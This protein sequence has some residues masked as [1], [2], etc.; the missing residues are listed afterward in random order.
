MEEKQYN[1]PSGTA[2]PSPAQA[3][4]TATPN[5]ETLEAT[6]QMAIPQ[7]STFEV[8]PMEPRELEHWQAYEQAISYELFIRLDF[9]EPLCEF[10]P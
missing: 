4:A 10:Q 5:L 8:I 3:T 7:E 9:S 6:A 1:N 2:S